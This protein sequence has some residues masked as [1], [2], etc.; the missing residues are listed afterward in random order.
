MKQPPEANGTLCVQVAINGQSTNK[1]SRPDD[2]GDDQS[3]TKLF[4]RKKKRAVDL[5]NV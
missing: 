5:L 3:E 1:Y 2:G 4:A